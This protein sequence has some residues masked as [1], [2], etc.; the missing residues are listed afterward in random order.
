MVAFRSIYFSVGS[1]VA[2]AVA[3][4]PYRPVVMMHGMNQDASHVQRNMDAL[5]QKY[6]GIY[7]VSLPVYEGMS[8]MVTGVQEQLD[9]VTNAI[10]AD[11]NLANGFNFY[12]E[13][14]G[15]LLAR[16]FVTTVNVPPVHNLVAVNG[17]QSGVGECPKIEVPGLK[18]LCGT[19][20]TDLDIYHWPLC[21]F[22]DYWKGEDEK[23]YL[24]NSEWLAD[25]NNDR[26][27]NEQHRKNMMS[28]NKY[29][30][31]RATEDSV[32]QPSYSAWHTFWEWN[33]TWRSSVK[34]LNETEGYKNDALG[35]KTLNERGALILNEFPGDHLKYTMEWWDANVLPMFNNEIEDPQASVVLV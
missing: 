28:L 21:S 2:V 3:G 6:P 16:S 13:S 8:S 29:M 25:V 33:D 30:A 26:K 9:A 32:V 10:Q 14:Q 7:V 23:T 27:I 11:S 19:L 17:P 4:A 24:D 20:G 35:L 22:C 31:T 34:P 5:K 15:A 1:S 12:G 18:P